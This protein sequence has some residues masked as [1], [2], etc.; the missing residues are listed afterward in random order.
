MK[1]TI[2]L[3]DFRDAFIRANRKENFSY[4]GLEVLFDYLEDTDPDSELDVI[5]LCCEYCEM[6]LDE[7]NNDYGEGFD[8][9]DIERNA[10]NWPGGNPI[11]AHPPCRAWGQLSQNVSLR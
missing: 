1:Q 10:L 2:S 7:L 9:W 4:D 11:V 6:T 3:G 8:C 5:G